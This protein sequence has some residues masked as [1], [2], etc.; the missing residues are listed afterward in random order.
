MDDKLTTSPI[1][2]FFRSK[3]IY[4]TGS[5]L[6]AWSGIVT[7]GLGADKSLP[8]WLSWDDRIFK[9]YWRGAGLSWYKRREGLQTGIVLVCIPLTLLWSASNFSPFIALVILTL[10][11]TQCSRD[12]YGQD[13]T[14]LICSVD[15]LT[16]SPQTSYSNCVEDSKWEFKFWSSDFKGLI[17]HIYISL[18]V[19]PCLWDSTPMAGSPRSPYWL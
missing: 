16:T 17:H 7:N 5:L 1:Y 4:R 3:V 12:D 2:I 8:H 6:R 15:I 9:R 19:D 11:E 13:H 18:N 10:Y 14:R